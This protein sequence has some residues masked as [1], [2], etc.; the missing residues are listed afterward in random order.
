MIAKIL[1]FVSSIDDFV[2][3]EMAT[4]TTDY[5]VSSLMKVSFYLFLIFEIHFLSC[6]Y[7]NEYSDNKAIYAKINK[8]ALCHDVHEPF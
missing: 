3:I 8:I 4:P 2:T 6:K 1:I 7:Q 5:V